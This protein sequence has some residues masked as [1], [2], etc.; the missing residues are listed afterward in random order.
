MF[1]THRGLVANAGP[2]TRE[3]RGLAVGGPQGQATVCRL[4]A[5]GTAGWQPAP[6][7]LRYA[8]LVALI[9]T[10][11]F[12]T[13][14]RLGSVMPTG[15]QRGAEL[16]LS[17][18]GDRLQDTEEVICYEPGI[19]VQHLKLVTN[20]VVRAE[21]KIAPD[22]PLGEHHLRLR[23][24]SGLSQVRTFF[25][26][27]YPVVAESEPNNTPAQVQKIRMNTTVAGVI[28]AEDVDCF[29]VQAKKGERLSAEVEG[30]RLGR[31][32]FDPRL[33]LLE[34]NGT[35]LADVD[36]TWLGV[37]DPFIS[38]NAPHDGTYILQLH[39]ATYGGRDDCHYRLHVGNF[40][41]PTAV[42]P[43]GGQA[44]EFVALHFFSDATDEFDQQLKLPPAPQ[45]KFG[46]FA[47]L[48]GATA[49]TPNWI[50][51]SPFPNVLING[52]TP[53]REHASPV[54]V[55]PPFALNGVISLKGEA[56]WYRFSAVK[57]QPLDVNVYARRLRSPLDSVIEVCDA[58][59]HTLASND[60]AGG[61]D[62][63]LK[64]TPEATTN[65]FISIR[66]TLGKFGRD[67]TYRIEITPATPAVAVKIPEVARNDTQSR[68]AM[69]IPRGNRFATLISAKRANYNGD[70]QFVAPGLPPGV[71]LASDTLGRAEDSEPLVFEAAPDAPIGGR[72]LDL[73]ATGTN[74]QGNCTG[75]YRQ[76]LTLVE[77]P[78]NTSYYTTA[79]NKFCVAVVKEAPFHLRIVEPK[80][81]LVQAGSMGLEVAVDRK[82]GFDEPVEVQMVWNPP[83][84]TSQTDASIA[85]GATNCLYQLNA[86]D[87]AETRTWKIAVLGHATVDGGEVYV[88]S[89]LAPLE[90]ASPFVSGKIETLVANPGQP[91]KLIVDL[92]QLKA[93]DGKARAHLLGLP[94]KV[95]A[96]DVDITKEDQKVAFPLAIDAKCTPGPTR[97]VICAVDIK[98][99]G[100]VIPQT[101]AS[102]GILRIVPLKREPAKLAAVQPEAK[103]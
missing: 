97:T 23:T 55:Q 62:S 91:A 13:E 80:V 1:E 101:V 78:N 53:D 54:D 44:G 86:S 67:F 100:Q 31:G 99:D 43:L 56:D 12:A 34:T 38:L 3:G 8:L 58:K 66:D 98:Q 68:Q 61:P 39:E 71:T 94:D 22:C 32:T 33:A 84:I 90:V 18:N 47:E 16:Q 57:G 82:Q 70:L 25:V 60:D 51:V 95:T 17:F 87:S 83:G 92:Q 6:R 85:R 7:G 15:G 93:F 5:G 10:S 11:A 24:A 88:S 75:N 20:K 36:D 19:E 48:D 77:G 49:P 42:Y 46:V 41:R 72:L 73:V 89:Q 64:F 26:G 59:G 52:Q 103:K 2:A 4:A 9:G 102:G 96:P 45:E 27:P 69:A 50:R 14:P 30:M 76:E 28:T 40:P 29:A 21:V 63:A 79:V 81:P 37:Q 65:Y 35:V 74:A